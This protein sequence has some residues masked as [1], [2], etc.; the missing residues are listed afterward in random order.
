MWT[1]EVERRVPG[2]PETVFE[3]FVDPDKHRQWR[4]LDAELDPRPGGLYRVTSAPGVWTRGEYVVVEPPHRVVLTWGFETAGVPLP[5]GL[6]QV[7]VGSS[8]VE[9]TFEADGDDTI[10]KVRH[11]GLPSPD[12]QRA[13]ERGWETYV[14]R[15]GGT[16]E[17]RDPGDDPAVALAEALFARERG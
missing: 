16:V 15:L 1:V 2:P 8:T 4:G 13:H 5:R 17:G 10:V 9:F 14:A 6:E 11:T 3:Y 7:P 12:A